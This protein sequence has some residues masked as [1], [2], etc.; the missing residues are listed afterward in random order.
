M[1]S[2]VLFLVFNRPDTTSQVFE[3]IRAARPPR[4]YIAADGPRSSRE[5]EKERC[6]EVRSIATNVDWPCEVKT[7]FRDENLGCKVG[8][9]EGIN[10]FFE[11]EEEGIILEDD[12]L[13]NL[14]FFHFC[15]ASLEKYRTN[16][17]VFSISGTNVLGKWASDSDVIFSLMGGNWGWASWRR[18]WNNYQ[19]DISPLCTEDNWG[20]I[21][22]LIKSKRLVSQLKDMM[23]AAVYSSNINTWDYQWLFIRMLNGGAS[24][25]PKVNLVTNI[26][27]R[28]DSTHTADVD[29]AMSLLPLYT[30]NKPYNFPSELVIDHKFDAAYSN[31]FSPS[32][33]Y[34]VLRLIKKL[35]IK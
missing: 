23:H 21:S 12:C 6:D 22:K 30:L 31:F 18:A 4:L 14:D 10:W 26:G 25:V 34:K 32:R 27:F 24:V 11:N 8:V 16:S 15:D 19:L 13:P 28:A 3:A 5:G 17:S 33:F 2:A 9:S 29:S 35:F 20:L 7:L 1:K